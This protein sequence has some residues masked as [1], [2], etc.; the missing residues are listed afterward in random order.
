M[1]APEA[2]TGRDEDSE[3]ERERENTAA[4]SQQSCSLDWQK[5][6]GLSTKK[7]SPFSKPL[8]IPAASFAHRSLQGAFQSLSY[9]CL[10]VGK[11]AHPCAGPYAYVLP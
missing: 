2:L 7:S 10:G 11:R 9:R 8:V 1:L 6:S 4:Q 5:A 3:T